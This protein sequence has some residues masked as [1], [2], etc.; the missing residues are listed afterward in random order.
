MSLA[1][2]YDGAMKSVSR[3]LLSLPRPYNLILY[4]VRLVC[5]VYGIYIV[6]IVVVQSQ[7]DVQIKLICSHELSFWH[8]VQNELCC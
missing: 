2:Y 3:L 4:R 8:H 5:R 1:W 6:S 7:H